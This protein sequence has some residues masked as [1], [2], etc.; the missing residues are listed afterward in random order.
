M[1]PR[2]EPKSVDQLRAES[3]GKVWVPPPQAPPI[4]KQRT[5]AK[6]A[7][8]GKEVEFLKDKVAALDV[9]KSGKKL[10]PQEIRQGIDLLFQKYDFSPVEELIKLA[11]STEKEDL[12]A[13]ICMFLVEFILPKLKSIE[14]SGSVDH[15]HT[16]VI[17]RFGKE[18]Q[19]LEQPRVPG[20]PSNLNKDAAE[21]AVNKVIDAEVVR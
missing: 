13:R 17:R 20:L 2:S 7:Q 21:G 16:V 1:V 9:L 18:D 4:D 10:T 5:Q 11:M 3:Q 8:L 15:N 12:S 19:Q 6:A 14:V